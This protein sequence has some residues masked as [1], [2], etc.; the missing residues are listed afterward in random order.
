MKSLTHKEF[1][2][3]CGCPEEIA[4]ING[5]SIFFKQCGYG[6]SFYEIMEGDKVVQRADDLKSAEKI[7]NSLPTMQTTAGLTPSEI[8]K[9]WRFRTINNQNIEEN[10]TD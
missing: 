4:K 8:E 1:E 6:I 10:E 9:G 7:A 5:R 2:A 3:T